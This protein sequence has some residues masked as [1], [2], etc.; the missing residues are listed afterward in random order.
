MPEIYVGTSRCRQLIHTERCAL[1]AEEL[2]GYQVPF[3]SLFQ[4]VLGTMSNIIEPVFC[5][6]VGAADGKD[7]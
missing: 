2:I 1:F 7:P 4:V 6:A 3:G 5:V